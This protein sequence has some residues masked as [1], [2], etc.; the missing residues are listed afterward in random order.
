MSKYELMVILSAT[1]E[2]EAREKLIEKIQSLV[3]T[4]NGTVDNV[5]KWGIR[6]FAYPINYKNEGYYLVMQITC[7]P[8]LPNAVEKQLLL[9]ENVVR[10]IFV[11]M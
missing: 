8:S 5:D 1:M 2:D 9:T 7:A 6:K 11:K 4:N 10:S 3:E